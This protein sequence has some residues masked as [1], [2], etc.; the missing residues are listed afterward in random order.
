[1][2]MERSAK[3]RRQS[4]QWLNK[5]SAAILTIFRPG[6]MTAKGRRQIAQ[7]LDKQKVFLLEHHKELGGRYRARYL[8]L[9]EK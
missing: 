8:Y 5:Q 7:W 9:E 4:V 3:G 6:D 2:V 1:M